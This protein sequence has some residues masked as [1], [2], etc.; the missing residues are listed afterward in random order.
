MTSYR[1]LPFT[2][3]FLLSLH[4]LTSLAQSVP[5]PV[6]NAPLYEFLGELA[7]TGSLILTAP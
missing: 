5:E 4:I 3:A 1:L 2:V 6:A 7:T